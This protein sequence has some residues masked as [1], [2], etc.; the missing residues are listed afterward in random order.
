MKRQKHRLTAIEIRNAKKDVAD[1]YGLWCQV[2]EKYGTKAWLFR[3]T[4]PVSKKPDSMGFGAVDAVSL[5]K[6]R[7]LA[8]KA[9][10]QIADG[11]NPRLAR[12]AQRASKRVQEARAM[13]FLECA[14]SYIKAHESGWKSAI[15]R[16]Q[17][18]AT[19]HETSRYRRSFPAATS[20]INDLPV[21]AIDTPLVVKV[22]EPIW[23]TKPESASRIRARLERVLAW[24]TVAH[25]RSGDNPARW[26]GHL[27]ELLPAKAKLAKIEHHAAV[28]YRELP[29]FMTELRAKS[30]KHMRADNDS[31]ERANAPRTRAIVTRIPY[32]L[33]L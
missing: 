5:A 32:N 10:D 8:Q 25:L 31:H 2:S 30:G 14:D 23:Y 1:G 15:H 3:F 12:D 19:F 18:V 6:A 29:E 20:A 22:L 9:R 33:C 7:E 21:A 17:W 28:A 27:K 11:A 24:A 13:T 4:C 16:N 26:D